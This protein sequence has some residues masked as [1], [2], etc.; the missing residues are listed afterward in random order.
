MA[1]SLKS[2]FGHLPFFERAS[3]LNQ[4]L[5]AHVSFPHACVLALRS[6]VQGLGSVACAKNARV[7]GLIDAARVSLIAVV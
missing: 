6:L 4:M 5:Q 2:G 1:T 3:D 7:F